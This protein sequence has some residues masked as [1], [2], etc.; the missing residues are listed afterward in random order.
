[1]STHTLAIT[2]I[3]LT[4]TLALLGVGFLL[5]WALT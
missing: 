5:G 3:L 1:M 4:W 2:A